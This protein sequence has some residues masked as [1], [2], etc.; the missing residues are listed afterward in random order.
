MRDIGPIDL[1]TVPVED[2]GIILSAAAAE[3]LADRLQ[4]RVVV[5]TH[6]FIEGLTDPRSGFKGIDDWRGRQARLRDLEGATLDLRRED[7][8]EERE[9]WVFGSC[10]ALE[11]LRR[12]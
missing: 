6:Y 7:L 12:P 11:R 1:L 5:P 3:R 9:G 2:A 4:P 10:L 8:P